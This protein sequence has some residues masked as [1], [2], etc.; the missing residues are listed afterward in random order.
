M[1]LQLILFLVFIQCLQLSAQTFLK[2]D[3]A[4][5]IEWK[6]AKRLSWENY[7]IKKLQKGSGELFALTS[8]IHSVR[9][10]VTDGKPNFEVKVLFVKKDSWSTTDQNSALL[11]HEQLHFDLA[12]LY[13]RKIRNDIEALGKGNEQDLKVYKRR[14]TI[15]LAQFK[16][17]S[18]EYDNETVHGQEIEEQKEWEMYVNSELKRLK[19]FK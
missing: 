15:L 7:Q 16:A 12:E 13:G 4:Q 3:T 17:R 1:K 5:F 18:I 19:K 9:G 14:I 10:E 8:V 2:V 6:N 11:A